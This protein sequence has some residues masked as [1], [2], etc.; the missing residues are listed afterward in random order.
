MGRGK[1][2]RF[3]EGFKVLSIRFNAENI[4]LLKQVL[5]ANGIKISIFLQNYVNS[6]AELVRSC[7]LSEKPI[8]EFTILELEELF[9]R[10]QAM[11]GS[12]K[13]ESQG[14]Q[15]KVLPGCEKKAVSEG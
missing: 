13:E 3:A 4:E 1:S 5:N 6:M 7:A 12:A 8:K 14:L 11:L 15:Q 10:M 2:T 9:A